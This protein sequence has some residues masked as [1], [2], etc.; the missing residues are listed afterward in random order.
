MYKAEQTSNWN[1][2][3]TYSALANIW[4]RFSKM[5]GQQNLHSLPNGL[6]V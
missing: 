4:L 6:G 5:K 1:D 3:T 2:T